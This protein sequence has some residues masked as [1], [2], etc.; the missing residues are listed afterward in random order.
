MVAEVSYIGNRGLDLTTT[1]DLNPIPRDYLSASLVRDQAAIDRLSAEVRNPFVGVSGFQ[2]TPLYTNAT[3]QRQQLLR[4]FPQFTGIGSQ[5]YDG[6]SNYN[7]GT[8]RVEKRFGH[9]YTLLGSYTFSKGL[10]KIT[11][12]NPTDG[13]YEKRLG[14]ADADRKSTRLNSSHIQ[15]SRMPSSA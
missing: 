5:R 10:E 7:S 3:V 8:L 15:K 4:P 11:Q 12:L 6:S 1:T 14:D 9:G 2:G 13:D